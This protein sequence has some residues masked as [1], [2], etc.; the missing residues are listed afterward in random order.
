MVNA[1]PGS[2]PRCADMLDSL[3]DLR[4]GEDR[5]N[6]PSHVKT[7]MVKCSRPAESLLLEKKRASTSL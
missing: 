6:N 7:S 2:G 5:E 4:H 1:F 3:I